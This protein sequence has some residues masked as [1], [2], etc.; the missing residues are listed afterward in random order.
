MAK[1][2]Y[3]KFF[4]P[5]L[6]II[7]VSN[8]DKYKQNKTN[9]NFE[10]LKKFKTIFFIENFFNDKSIF[11]S[12]FLFSKKKKG[13]YKNVPGNFDYDFLYSELLD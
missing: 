13:Y 12:N 11:S 10:L 3:K 7:Y 5:V 4:L 2:K 1:K 8:L 6:E 9:I